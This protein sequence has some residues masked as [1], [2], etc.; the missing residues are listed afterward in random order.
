VN[1]AKVILLKF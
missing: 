1:Y